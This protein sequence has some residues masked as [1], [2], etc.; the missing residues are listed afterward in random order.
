M[1]IGSTPNIKKVSDKTG[2]DPSSAIGYLH[3]AVLDEAMY[4]NVHNL[5]SKNKS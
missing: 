2:A 1:V 5:V 4:Y 3:I